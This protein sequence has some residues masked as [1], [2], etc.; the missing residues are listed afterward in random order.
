MD[1]TTQNHHT[2]SKTLRKEREKKIALGHKEDDHE[3]EQNYTWQQM[4]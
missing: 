1:S 3:E 4:L 2:D